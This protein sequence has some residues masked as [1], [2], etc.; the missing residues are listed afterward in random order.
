MT[1]INYCINIAIRVEYMARPVIYT[2]YQYYLCIKDTGDA[3]AR[4]VSEMFGVSRET[5]L[6]HLKRCVDTGRL[7]KNKIGAEYIFSIKEE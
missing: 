3:I 2:E 6:K 5:A 1:P 7:K 4:E